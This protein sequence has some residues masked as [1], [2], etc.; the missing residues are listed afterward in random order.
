MSLYE[1]ITRI[2]KLESIE[3]VVNFRLKNIDIWPLLR[4]AIYGNMHR[5]LYAEQ[6]KIAYLKGGFIKAAF[7]KA[8]GKTLYIF[9]TFKNLDF[10]VFNLKKSDALFLSDGVSF[11]S[12]GEGYIDKLCYPIDEYLTQKKY[13]TITLIPREHNRNIVSTQGV[14]YI[15]SLVSLLTIQAKFFSKFNNEER[16]QISNLVEKINSDLGDKYLSTASVFSLLGHLLIHIAVFKYL[17]Q[18]IRP[19]VVFIVESYSTQGQAM[20]HVCQL[21]DIK[22]ID[23]QHGTTYDTHPAYTHWEN[24]PV[25]SYN[26]LVDGFFVWT[27]LGK[28]LIKKWFQGQVYLGTNIYLDQYISEKLHQDDE[29]RVT[30]HNIKYVELLHR[31]NK[32]I[33][34]TLQPGIFTVDQIYFFLKN[35]VW[36]EKYCWL[37]R[38]HPSMLDSVDSAKIVLGEFDNVELV[39]ASKNL[40][41]DVLKVSDLHITHCSSS[42]IE[43]SLL[44]V[45]SIILDYSGVE[46]CKGHVPSQDYKYI[47][48]LQNLKGETI[49]SLLGKNIGDRKEGSNTRLQRAYKALDDIMSD[50]IRR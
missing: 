16:H 22:C 3:N 1:I 50:V 14:L 42:T 2:N 17:L 12:R 9:N 4:I 21:L 41:F 36:M 27:P 45:P 34:V 7:N 43:A 35:N 19:S 38:L 6:R 5:V 20:T 11:V 15:S 8:Y 46:I 39:T 13:K 40:L 24:A 37:V 47:N 33:I 32:K 48:G 26:T 25:N 18:K 10:R 29:L 30:K 49:E 31:K 44:S 28:E 23:L